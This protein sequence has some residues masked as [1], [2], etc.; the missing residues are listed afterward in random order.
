MKKKKLIGYASLKEACKVARELALE[1]NS[2]HYNPICIYEEKDGSFTVDVQHSTKAIFKLAVDK[3]GT[4]YT[5][6]LVRDD[7]G[8]KTEKFI[9][10]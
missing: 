9:K 2:S 8:K 6:K 5:K 4:R 10:N 1:K 7:F 3:S